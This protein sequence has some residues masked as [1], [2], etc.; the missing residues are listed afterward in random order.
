MLIPQEGTKLKY[1]PTGVIYEVKKITGLFVI[2]SSLDGSSQILVEKKSFPSLFEPEKVPL[3]ELA[4][5]DA[6]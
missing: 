1:I 4:Q 3:A 6:A 2:L 5:D